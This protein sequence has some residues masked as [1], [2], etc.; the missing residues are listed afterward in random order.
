[1]RGLFALIGTTFGGSLG[2]WL[3]GLWNLPAAAVLCAVGT[4]VG[5][6]WGR[7]LFDDW[8]G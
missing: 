1:M 7:R 5:L 6:Y 3:G 8:L 4:G 2:W